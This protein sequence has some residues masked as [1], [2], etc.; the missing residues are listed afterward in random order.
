MLISTVPD[1]QGT[2]GKMLQRQL[3]LGATLTA[4]WF[5]SRL[6][7][8]QMLISFYNLGLLCW[9]HDQA[10]LSQVLVACSA[11]RGHR[12]SFLNTFLKGPAK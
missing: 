10:R 6:D 7:G 1:G 12:L 8:A 4:S 9:L 5:R 3:W 11:L 2:V